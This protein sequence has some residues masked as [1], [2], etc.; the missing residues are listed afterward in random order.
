MLQKILQNIVRRYALNQVRISE[1]YLYRNRKLSK[2][3]V[4]LFYDPTLYIIQW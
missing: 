3:V 4:D 2:L 1:D